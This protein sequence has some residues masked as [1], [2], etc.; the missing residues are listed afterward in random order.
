MIFNLIKKKQNLSRRDGNQVKHGSHLHPSPCAF[1]DTS[2]QLF[3]R[4]KTL[5]L[6]N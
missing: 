3:C 6:M 1:G 4:V 5:F 2:T